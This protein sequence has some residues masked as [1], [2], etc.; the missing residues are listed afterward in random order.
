MSLGFPVGC[1][2][3]GTQF[4]LPAPPM[5]GQTFA[6]QRCG[7]PFQPQ[8]MPPMMP[9]LAAPRRRQPN[10]LLPATIGAGSLV[11][12][13]LV[14]LVVIMMLRTK[15]QT[16][17]NQGGGTAGAAP[18]DG[19]ATTG[20]AA[21]PSGGGLLDAVQQAV[22]PADS[23]DE[24]VVELKEQVEALHAT[25]ATIR[26]VPS[27]DA[28]VT[29]LAEINAALEQLVLRGARLEPLSD[30]DYKAFRQRHQ[31]DAPDPAKPI[32]GTPANPGLANEALEFIALRTQRNAGAIQGILT[33]GLRPLPTPRDAAE[34]VEH[35]AILVCRSAVRAVARINGPSDFG[36][37]VAALGDATKKQALSNESLALQAKTTYLEFSVQPEMLISD[38]QQIIVDRHG[39][40]PALAK[41]VVDFSTARSNLSF[42][43]PGGMVPGGAPV[44]AS[45]LPGAGQPPFIPPAG[46]G[47][48]PLGIQ[49]FIRQFGKDSVIVVHCGKLTEARAAELEKRIVMI[50]PGSSATHRE[51]DD[52]FIAVK[53]D[54][55]V[56]AFAQQINFARVKAVNM[57]Q[58]LITIEP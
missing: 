15:G 48:L 37:A 29:R 3:C 57:G 18:A 32:G 9:G 25:L 49:L 45:G 20:P 44:A 7:R 19:S 14:V 53:Y 27:R 4:V 46:A 31:A 21:P 10:W 33:D 22:N 2:W 26:D 6:C 1:P 55:D 42:A 11:V 43:R 30:A 5:P 34:Q 56:T 39:D 54:G 52:T 38:L 40:D 8:V 36:A 35:D 23:P 24:I 16:V 51:N 58:R 13:L 17:A 41:A 28:A 12:L 50:A 47:T